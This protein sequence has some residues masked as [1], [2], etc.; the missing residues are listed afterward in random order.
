MKLEKDDPLIILIRGDKTARVQD[1]ADIIMSLSKTYYVTGCT[2]R[3]DGVAPEFLSVSAWE[4]REGFI[5]LINAHS[6]DCH[7]IFNV[8]DKHSSPNI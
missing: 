5:E 1:L 6:K 4:T 8:F 7:V 3:I 2:S